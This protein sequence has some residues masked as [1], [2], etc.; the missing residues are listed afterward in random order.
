MDN[1]LPLSILPPRAA[2]GKAEGVAFNV[3]MAA[4]VLLFGFFCVSTLMLA[5]GDFP[6]AV[7]T[8]ACILILYYAKRRYMRKTER[9]QEGIREDL[10]S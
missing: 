10:L 4:F 7:F 1:P 8:G 3:L 2:G 6:F 9:L 5:R